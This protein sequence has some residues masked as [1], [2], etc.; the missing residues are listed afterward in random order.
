M[1]EAEGPL[2]A[3]VV[4]RQGVQGVFVSGPCLGI[5]TDLQGQTAADKHT[6]VLG[7]CACFTVL[8]MP[9][10]GAA[11]HSNPWPQQA[12]V[13]QGLVDEPMQ[14][15]MLL[16]AAAPQPMLWAD[17]LAPHYC[18]HVVRHPVWFVLSWFPAVIPPTTRIAANMPTVGMRAV[19]ISQHDPAAASV[20][21]AYMIHDYVVKLE[22]QG[23]SVSCT[24][25]GNDR[26]GAGPRPG[27]AH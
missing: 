26:H 25:H 19:V 3:A 7:C 17:P 18:I 5:L 10:R 9:A 15:P 16:Q 11:H 22:L 8:A 24:S 1:L 27:H 2:Q 21:E 12:A 14:L 4:S 23:S 13:L 6:P 20:I